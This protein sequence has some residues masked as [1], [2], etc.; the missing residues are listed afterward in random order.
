MEYRQ[1]PDQPFADP[2]LVTAQP[3]PEP[4]PTTLQQLLS[5]PKLAAR[6]TG[7]SRLRRIQPISPSTLPLWLP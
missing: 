6:G 3:I 5:A 1:I 4:A 7:T 2:L